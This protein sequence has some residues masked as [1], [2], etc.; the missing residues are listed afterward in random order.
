MHRR[1]CSNVRKMPALER[2]RLVEVRWAERPADATY[3][4]D[5]FVVAA[6]RKGLLRDV[7]AVFSD[8]DVDV[9]G[10]H[11]VS[12]R[13]ADRAMMRFTVE[14]KDMAQLE[15][16]VNKLTQVPDVLNVRRPH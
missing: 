4:A 5:I 2:Q 6:D 9:F 16:V 13:A 11:T 15:Q 1:D 8:E 3:P 7:S 12:D 10:V 14:V